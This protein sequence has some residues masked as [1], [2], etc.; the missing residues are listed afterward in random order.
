MDIEQK[1]KLSNKHF[2]GYAV[3]HFHNDITV[4]AWGNF[5]VF[6]LKRVV[7]TSC[8]SS[9]FLIGQV[10]DG[11]CTPII[12]ILSDKCDTRIGKT[13]SIKVKEFPG[14]YLASSLCL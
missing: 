4:T 3:G 11:T 9:I 10:T 6:F 12:G 13:T 8:A 7:Q 1:D 5:L 2:W 14:I